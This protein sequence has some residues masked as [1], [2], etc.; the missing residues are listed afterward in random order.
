MKKFDRPPPRSRVRSERSAARGG[1]ARDLVKTG[2][3]DCLKSSF[4]FVY[5][6]KNEAEIQLLVD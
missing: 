1:D 3:K 4:S 2:G 5:Y 6:N